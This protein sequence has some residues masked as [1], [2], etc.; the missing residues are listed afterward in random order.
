MSRQ[1]GASLSLSRVLEAR[2]AAEVWQELGLEEM[3]DCDEEP[4][5]DWEAVDSGESEGSEGGGNETE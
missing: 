5:E 3:K 1:S 4:P 2:E